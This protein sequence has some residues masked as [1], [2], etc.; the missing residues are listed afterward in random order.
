V[1]PL[2]SLQLQLRRVVTPFLGGETVFSITGNEPRAVAAIRGG[3]AITL[4]DSAFSSL[5]RI[6]QADST[7]N[8]GVGLQVTHLSGNLGLAVFAD[9]TAAPDARPRLRLI[10]TPPLRSDLDQGHR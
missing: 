8:L 9:T 6:W 4:A 2:D 7:L 10:F 3:S 5:V 1:T